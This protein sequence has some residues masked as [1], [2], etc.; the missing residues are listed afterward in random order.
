[1]KELDK[2]FIGKG[3]VR[4]FKF[5]QLEAT[6][7]AYLYEVDMNGAIYYEVFK[8]RENT[9]FGCVSYPTGEAFGLWAQTI[10][11][12]NK[13]LSYFNQYNERNG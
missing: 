11:D 12:Y 10:R 3:E 5:T 8:R 1:M 4:G 6:N 13:A 9:R 2:E 7:Q